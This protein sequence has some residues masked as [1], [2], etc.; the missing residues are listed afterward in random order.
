MSILEAFDRRSWYSSGTGSERGSVRPV[1][2]GPVTDVAPGEEC[3]CQDGDEN[4]DG[5]SSSSTGT[6]RLLGDGQQS[7][8]Q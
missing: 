6:V 2:F 1:R 3:G 8:R 7:G 5:S 4:G